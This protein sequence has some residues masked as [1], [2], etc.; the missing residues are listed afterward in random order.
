MQPTDDVLH[1]SCCLYLLNSEA[2]A[3]EALQIRPGSI[4]WA[5]D[6]VL[7]HWVTFRNSLGVFL[8]AQKHKYGALSQSRID[9]SLFSVF[10]A[11]RTCTNSLRKVTHSGLKQ[12]ASPVSL[13][14]DPF[15]CILV[16]T[17]FKKRLRR[18]FISSLCLLATQYWLAQ[19]LCYLWP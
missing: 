1:E 2:T 14:N 10:Q 6:L 13:C 11:S 9:L 5:F 4:R 17:F 16:I 8:D 15:Q 19:V 18:R 7:Y 12:P 3:W